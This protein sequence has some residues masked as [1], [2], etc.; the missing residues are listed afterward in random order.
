M[1]LGR[2]LDLLPG[3]L[4][5]DDGA[6]WHISCSSI[7]AM[8]FPELLLGA[9]LGATCVV[10]YVQWGGRG[11]RKPLCPLCKTSLRCVEPGLRQC[12]GCGLLFRRVRRSGR[13]AALPA[14]TGLRSQRDRR[15]SNG[16]A[17]CRSDRRAVPA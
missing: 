1:R 13:V 14:G 5:P 2:G 11:E 4:R 12:D 7:R 8:S 15:E 10:A 16:G 9:V 6:L 3:S 17:S